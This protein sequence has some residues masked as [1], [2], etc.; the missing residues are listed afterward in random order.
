M[1]I[2][3]TISAALLA[4]TVITAQA[5]VISSGP[6]APPPAPS[7]DFWSGSVS[8]GYDTDY[9]FRGFETSEDNLWGSLDLNFNLSDRWTLNLNAW[10]TSSTTEVTGPGIEYDELNLYARLFYKV[11]DQLSFGPSLRW[12]D[13]PSIPNV[14]DELEAGLEL[15]YAPCACSNVTFGVFYN[16]ELDALYAEL[17]ASYTFKLTDRVSL[18]PGAVIGYRDV[19]DTDINDFSHATLYVK[20]PIALKENVTL[21]PYIAGNFPMDGTDEA[22]D[23]F[24]MARQDDEIY[25]GVSLTVGF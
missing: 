15:A 3:N 8:L 19:E 14:N 6:S 21:T 12:Y 7:S 17:G 18:V 11:N 16:E 5:G 1:T 22:T 20:M 23:A 13:Y 2:R 4:S 10:F 25:G 9:I 24:E